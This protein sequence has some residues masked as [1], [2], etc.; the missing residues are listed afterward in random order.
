VNKVRTQK[1]AK[2]FLVIFLAAVGAALIL[3]SL[4]NKLDYFYSPKD[5]EIIEAPRGNFKLGGM[6]QVGSIKLNGTQTSFILTD[7]ESS[8]K[9]KYTGVTPD[10]FKE[11]SGAVVY[12]YLDAKE[13]IALELYAKHDENYMPPAMLNLE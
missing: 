13:F 10:L 2:I 4:N 3:F 5:L 1:G 12:G 6:V 9:V 7:F 11:N 8:I